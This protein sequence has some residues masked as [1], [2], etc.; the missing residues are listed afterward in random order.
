MIALS[1]RALVLVALLLSPIAARAQGPDHR[2][3]QV[4]DKPVYR[5]ER[6]SAPIPPRYHVRNEGGS[7]GAGLC[8]ISSVLANG[9]YQ[10]VP[11]LNV[12][13]P[14][15][16]NGEPA[17]AGKGSEL[18]R[19]AKAAPGGYSPDKLERLI[20]SS[21]YRN[22]KYASFVGNGSPSDFET[23][24]KLSRA[25]YPVGA[26]MNTGALYHYQPI[27]HMVSLTHYRRDGWAQVVD[28]NRPGFYSVMPA[29]EWNRRWPDMGITWAWIWTRLPAVL[30]RHKSHTVLISLAILAGTV[31]ILAIRHQAQ[32]ED[33]EAAQWFPQSY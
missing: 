25:G 10:G 16:P 8:V 13:G 12:P 23:L 6:A 24:E 15:G 21:P 2:G 30:A 29:S 18:W 11:G 7:D 17:Q 14:R 22:E 1:R 3:E 9:M 4:L 26:T 27:H 33:E 28:N 20:Q 5:G 19:R 31:F 32:A